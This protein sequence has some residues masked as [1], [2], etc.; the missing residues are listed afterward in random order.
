VV[1]FYQLFIQENVFCL[2][3]LLA[4]QC[5]VIVSSATCVDVCKVRERERERTSGG[6][7]HRVMTR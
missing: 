1:I 3:H 7:S 6:T 2:N 4:V 5:I